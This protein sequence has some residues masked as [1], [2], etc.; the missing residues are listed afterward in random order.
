MNEKRENEKMI[1]NVGSK[2]QHPM[3]K[4][5]TFSNYFGLIRKISRRSE[6]YLSGLGF[7]AETE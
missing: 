5:A 4:N 2:K 6:T 1:D 3:R 7:G